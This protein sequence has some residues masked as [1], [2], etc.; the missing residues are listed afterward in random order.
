MITRPLLIAPLTLML[1]LWG[2]APPAQV[3][4]VPGPP[5]STQ[6]EALT[7]QGSSPPA[8]DA[9]GLPDPTDVPEAP[10]LPDTTDEPDA[11]GLTEAPEKPP[12][13]VTATCASLYDMAAEDDRTCEWAGE[14]IY[15]SE[16]LAQ[17]CDVDTFRG[18]LREARTIYWGCAFPRELDINPDRLPPQPPVFTPFF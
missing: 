12:L 4:P 5:P 8:V 18:K 3:D 11:P 7:P 15:A 14:L 16:E 2:C 9:A 10:D 13:S 1:L 6:D 17:V